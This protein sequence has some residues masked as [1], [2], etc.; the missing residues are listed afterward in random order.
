MRIVGDRGGVI[1]AKTATPEKGGAG[2]VGRNAK[3]EERR[4]HHRAPP[5]LPSGTPP[6][7]LSSFRSCLFLSLSLS[8]SIFIS[9]LSFVF[10]GIFVAFNFSDIPLVFSLFPSDHLLLLLFT[11][12]FTFSMLLLSSQFQVLAVK[13]LV[14]LI[15]FT[16]PCGTS[17]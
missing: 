4:S 12:L 15:Q 11:F 17:V 10:I 3:R 16:G 13:L 5:P 2:G 6:H 8:L 14:S 7:L 1:S 9:P